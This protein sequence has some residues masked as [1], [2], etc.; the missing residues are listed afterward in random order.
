MKSNYLPL[1]F[2]IFLCVLS[3]SSPSVAQKIDSLEVRRVI[4]YLASDEM[5]GRKAGS[6]FA[7]KAAEFIATEFEKAGLDV[8]DKLETYL[9][10]FE[11]NG[12][13]Y[14]NVVGVL[15]G[16]NLKNEIVLFSAHYDHIGVLRAVDGDSI[17]N[18]ADDDAS[19]VTALITLAQ[20]FKEKNDNERTLI[21]AAFTAEEIGGYGSRYFA[22]EI[23]ARQYIAGINIEMIGKISKFGQNAAFITGFEKSDL[24]EILNQNVEGKKFRFEPDP[25]PS[26]NLFYR[27]DNARFAQMGIPAHT[28]SSVQIDKDRYYHSVNDEVSTLD[29]VNMTAVI[30]GIAFGVSSIVSGQD[31][32][33]RIKDR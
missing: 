31:T 24:G 26:Q 15:P 2:A 21:F 6:P 7:L 1:C 29:I 27:S 13:T 17:A 5:Q 18:G 25:Y 32:P 4:E 28:V 10:V 22:D 8:Y 33:S 3:C 12:K 30:Q 9:Q 19:G 16:K 14:Q 23:Q 20:Y 11:Y